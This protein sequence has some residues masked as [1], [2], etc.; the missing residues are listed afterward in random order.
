MDDHRIVEIIRSKRDGCVLSAADYQYLTT[1]IAADQITEAQLGAFLMAT[2]CQSLS[3]T[4]SAALTQA[5]AA[6]GW[7]CNWDS[8]ALT[9][10]VLDKHSTGGLGDIVSFLLA[11]MVAACGG[12]VPMI[13]GRSLE[14]TGGTIDKLE[15]IP[16]YNPFPT[17]EQF[18][19]VVVDHGLAIVGQTGQMV[20]ADQRI[21]AVRGQTATVDSLPLI[22]ASI[23]SKKLAEDLDGLVIDLKIGGGAFM[24]NETQGQPLMDM[25]NSVAKA[26]GLNCKVVF[27][28]MDQPLANCIGDGVEMHEAVRYLTGERRTPRLHQTTLKLSTELLL[29]GG[30]A[31]EADCARAK[32]ESVLDSGLAA[33]YFQTMV[34][35]LGGP[36][37]FLEN[38]K[39]HLSQAAT[40]HPV[41]APSDG[42]VTAIDGRL[43]GNAIHQI[44]TLKAGSGFDHRVG[45][46]ELCQLQDQ[47]SA[48]QQIA[49]VHARCEDEY[50][51]LANIVNQAITIT[52]H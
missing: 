15:S 38:P 21:Y 32:L 17:P 16:G 30:L 35:A 51:Q 14:H 34:A 18:Q 50:Q 31:E 3:V 47:V 48:D 41:N 26:C 20:P 43:L 24:L 37:D 19:R 2:Y 12:F 8:F 45:I 52:P 9:G 6:S 13:S 25:L 1:C 40:I 36:V 23:L 46:A 49:L 10:P 28:A 29:S 39:T 7:R 33:E 44:A 5:M 11:P 22:A 27:T 42:L 4:E